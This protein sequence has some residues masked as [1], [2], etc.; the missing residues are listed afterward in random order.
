MLRR[1][2]KWGHGLAIRIPSSLA[3]ELNI[4]PGCEVE[5]RL[6]EGRLIVVPVDRKRRLERLVA[7]IREENLHDETDWGEK[8]G[9]E[10]W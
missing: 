7:E 1:V 4:G 8:I 3:K 5:L 2:Q 10:V 6:E 9:K